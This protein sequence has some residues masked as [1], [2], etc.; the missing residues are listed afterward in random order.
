MMQILAIR[1][2]GLGDIVM[3]TGI[4]GAL[5]QRY[6]GCRITLLADVV[7]A[8]IAS[9]TSGLIDEVITLNRK[10]FR[11]RRLLPALKEAFR[12][13]RAV[14]EQQY[15][16]VLDFQNFGETGFITRM[17]HAAKKIGAPKK[18]KYA[19]PYD[20][21]VPVR[22][23]GHRI[24]QFARIA[25]LE[26]QI[27]PPK[28]CLSENG[29]KYAASWKQGLSRDLPVVGLNIGST[30][31]SRRWHH[32]RF[33]ELAKRLSGQAEV[34]IFAGPAEEQYLSSFVDKG[35]LVRSVTLP[36]LCGAISCCDLIVSN[37]TG[38]AH[39]AG[40]LGVPLVTLFSTGDDHEVGAICNQKRYIKC[41][42][43]NEI[44]VDEV[45]VQMAELLPCLN[46][47]EVV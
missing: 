46:L 14:R 33:A 39:I 43:I 41:V 6:P 19:K 3:L 29:R 9:E 18:H 27:Y 31:E 34:V 10:P 37:D 35:H 4:F 44:Q 2:S 1:F 32:E 17:A 42:P 23:D 11:Q 20:V 13:L 38:P 45:L 22:T 26:R 47:V 30:Q 24:E 28:L 8:G 36:Q 16:M 25:Q 7:N 5:K 12:V 15:D 21:V 40:A